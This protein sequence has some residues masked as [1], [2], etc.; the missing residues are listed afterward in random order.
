VFQKGGERVSA[1]LV[2]GKRKVVLLLECKRDGKTV[3]D[4]VGASYLLQRYFR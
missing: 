3:I 2:S 4:F 1:V